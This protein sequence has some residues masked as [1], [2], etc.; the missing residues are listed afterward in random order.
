MEKAVINLAQGARM[1]VG[2]LRL[3]SV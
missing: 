2:L 1:M 3:A